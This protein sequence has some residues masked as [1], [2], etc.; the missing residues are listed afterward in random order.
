MRIELFS[1]LLQSVRRTTASCG[2]AAYTGLERTGH[3]Q[4]A[5][6]L[7]LGPPRLLSICSTRDNIGGKLE[8]SIRKTVLFLHIIGSK[9]I[10]PHGKEL[11]RE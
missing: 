5:Q 4:G 10:K 8:F 3:C 9:T 7:G 1:F 11:L 2:R 6:H